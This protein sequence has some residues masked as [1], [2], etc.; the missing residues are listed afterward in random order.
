MKQAYWWM[1]GMVGAVLIVGSGCATRDVDSQSLDPESVETTA[2]ADGGAEAV[3]DTETGDE[4]VLTPPPTPDPALTDFEHRRIEVI[5][6][7]EAGS[8]FAQ[9]RD[10]LATAIEERDR[11]FITALIPSDGLVYGFGGAMQPADLDLDDEDSWFWQELDK[12]I[13]P[14]S[15][16][17][18]DYPTTQAGEDVWVCP[19]ISASFYRQYPPEAP[20][21]EEGLGAEFET[22]IVYGRNVNVRSAPT[23]EA[24]VV[25]ILTN[26]LVTL[27][28]AGMEELFAKAADEPFGAVDGWTAVTLPNQVRGYVYNQYVYQPL[29]PRML[30]EAVGGED[31]QMVRV[32]AGD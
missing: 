26:E 19:N 9:F 29:S 30:F 23:T 11:D 15:C 28:Q 31:W 5:D 24:E 12:M 27:D 13:S 7:V 3:E 25:G 1:V 16:E 17:V 14:E 4:A 2:Q 8:D 22:V 21:E 10:R 32:L 18:A 6:K 20:T